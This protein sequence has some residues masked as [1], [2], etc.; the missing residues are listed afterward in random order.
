M[1]AGSWTSCRRARAPPLGTRAH[2]HIAMCAHS[3]ATTHTRASGHTCAMIAAAVVEGVTGFTTTVSA[4]T[5]RRARGVGA[6]VGARAP[7][8][9]LDARAYGRRA[10]RGLSANTRRL[11]RRASGVRDATLPVA[12]PARRCARAAAAAAGRRA[13]QAPLAPE[14]VAPRSARAPLAA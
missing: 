12:F 10:V 1:I 11:R 14:G 4:C 8:A 6:R 2:A 9:A 5:P 13:R 7:R 3:T